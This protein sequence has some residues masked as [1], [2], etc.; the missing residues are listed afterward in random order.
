MNLIIIS[1]KFE[2]ILYLQQPLVE[3]DR[4]VILE[5]EGYG[6]KGLTVYDSGHQK[7]HETLLTNV[8]YSIFNSPICICIKV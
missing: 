2:S 1:T 3:K 6:S 5:A 4:T 7:L 8:M